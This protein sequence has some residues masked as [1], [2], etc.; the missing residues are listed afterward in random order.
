M[1]NTQK[2]YVIHNEKLMSEWDEEENKKEGFFPEELTVGSKKK[3]NWICKE[4]HKWK[5]TICNRNL[6]TNCPYCSGKLP[7]VGETDLSSTHPEIA[8]QLHPTLNGKLTGKDISSG[9]NKKL[10]WICDKNHEWQ[11]TVSNRVKKNGC[12]YCSGRLPIV[13]ETDLETTHPEIANQLNPFMNGTI[14]SKDLTAGS[15][16]K[17]WWTCQDNHDWQTTVYSRTNGSACP[18]CN[19]RLENN[20]TVTHPQIA[21]EIH[22]T[23]NGKIKAED[24]T[25]GSGKQLYWICEKNHIWKTTVNSRKRGKG[26]PY[27]SKSKTDSKYEKIIYYY[28]REVFKDC[29]AN[30][31]QFGKKELDIF[32]PSIKVAIEFDGPRH[33]F[34]K[35]IEKNELCKENDILLIRV[36][37]YDLPKL[38]STSIDFYLDK[39]CSYK[40]L[41]NSI[42]DIFQLINEKYKFNYNINIDSKKD[43]IKAMQ[44]LKLTNIQNSISVTHPEIAKE[45]HPAKN[46]KLTAEM[47]T[48]GSGQKLYWQCN[49][50]HIWKA[51]INSR[52]DGHNCPYC[53]GLKTIIGQNDLATEYP[54]I[55]KIWDKE[56]NGDLTPNLLKSKSRKKIWIIKNSISKEVTVSKLTKSKYF[57]KL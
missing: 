44:Y 2:K 14:K 9:S 10:W 21:K 30:H 40:S 19:G 22:P 11:S 52:V 35:D 3:T 23:K 18:Y 45:I 6:G 36:R 46:G 28:I 42:T 56:K 50:N 34:E 48:A 49:K 55:H 24:L 39:K 15:T 17:L 37:T 13:G 41:D 1:D 38:N 20:L 53:S 25:A 12:P 33:K 4:N 26:C 7:I 51:T 57:Q 54:Q 5:A 32:I 27:C 16:K 43:E 31:K 8:N 47:F 29:L